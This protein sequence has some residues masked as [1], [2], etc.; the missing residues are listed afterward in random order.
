MQA[1]TSNSTS[2]RPAVR[3]CLVIVIVQSISR[4]QRGHPLLAQTRAVRP[5]QSHRYQPV[6]VRITLTHRCGVDLDRA[7]VNPAGRLNVGGI[8]SG[9]EGLRHGPVGH[10][11]PRVKPDRLHLFL[12]DLSG[13]E[14]FPS[15]LNDGK[16]L[17][18]SQ[19]ESREQPRHAQHANHHLYKREPAAVGNLPTSLENNSHIRSIGPFAFM[20]PKMGLSVST[21]SKIRS[22]PH[23][24]VP[25]QW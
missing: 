11:V 5:G 3:T 21:L 14:V 12:D 20:M 22:T 2:V 6:L 15:G 19:V 7:V 17:T 9:V 23:S 1:A 18:Q 24:I 4:D 25:R 10:L 16:T 8:V 13:A